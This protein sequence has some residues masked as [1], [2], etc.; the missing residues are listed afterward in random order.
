MT[1]QPERQEEYIHARLARAGFT[2]QSLVAGRPENVIVRKHCSERMT[3]VLVPVSAIRATCTISSVAEVEK[4]L[5][6]GIGRKRIFGF[7][8]PFRVN[9]NDA[10]Y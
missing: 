10:S 9:D 2:A 5:V 1:P 4:A 8:K 7:L 6:Y 3:P